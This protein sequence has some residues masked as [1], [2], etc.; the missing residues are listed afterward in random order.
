MDETKPA[1]EDAHDIR[2]EP[3]VEKFAAERLAFFTDAVV[4]IAI[5]LLALELKAPEGDSW[6]QV[7]ISIGER[8]SE[9]LAFGITFVVI[10]AAWA[11]HHRMFRYVTR[12]DGRLLLLNLGW[13][14]MI[15]VAPFVTRMIVDDKLMFPVGFVCY[16][17]V[18]V[19]LAGVMLLM[20]GHAQR[21]HLF[22]SHTPPLFPRRARI[23]SLI[24]GLPFL[25]SIPFVFV[26]G[27][28]AGA[29]VFWWAGPFVL[30]LA[31]TIR[32]RLELRRRG[33]TRASAPVGGR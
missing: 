23:R 25:V 19:V 3:E 33:R 13:L 17:V 11:G 22:V 21:H 27:V 14:L 4:A 1:G 7:R 28:G 10:A 32:R 2:D 18:Q 26:P 29:F 16:A 9:Y 12:A 8:S 31:F 30:A 6:A 5:T 24:A 20:L 15:V